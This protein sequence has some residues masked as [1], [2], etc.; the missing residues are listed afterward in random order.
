M[1]LSP[2]EKKRFQNA[3]MGVYEKYC[4]D[5]MDVIERIIDEGGAAEENGQ[6]EVFTEEG[7]E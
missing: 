5:Q 2:E 6:Q 3:V 7:T 4:G 1:E